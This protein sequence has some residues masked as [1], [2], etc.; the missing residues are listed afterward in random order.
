MIFTYYDLILYI[1]LKQFVHI[2][3]LVLFFE[4][5]HAMGNGINFQYQDIIVLIDQRQ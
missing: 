4:S 3:F 2:S 5:K 1:I